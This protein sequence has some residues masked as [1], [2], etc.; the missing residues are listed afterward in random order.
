[1]LPVFPSGASGEVSLISRPY[2][3][4]DVFQGKNKGGIKGSI[5]GSVKGSSRGNNEDKIKG[6]IEGSSKGNNKGAPCPPTQ[7]SSSPF[8][9]AVSMVFSRAN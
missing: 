8:P 7:C 5:K 4:F 2:F 9:Q 1:M 6:N 3:S